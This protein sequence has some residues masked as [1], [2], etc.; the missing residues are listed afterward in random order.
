MGQVD[1]YPKRALRALFQDWSKR[2]RRALSLAAAF[3][4]GLSAALTVLIVVMPGSPGPVGWYVL[5]ASHTA[6]IASLIFGVN[7]MF[8]AHDPR[9]ISQVRGALGEDNTRCELA[10]AKRKGVIWGWVDSVPYQ[11]GDIDHVV[12]TRRGGVVA[13]DSKW[14]SSLSPAHTHELS[15]AANRAALLTA[16]LARTVLSPDRGEHRSRAKAVRVSPVIALWGA[17]RDEL[18][19][20]GVDG[21]PIVTGRGVV[22]WL[23][24]LSGDDVDEDA[25]RELIRLIEQHAVGVRGRGSRPSG[26]SAT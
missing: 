24:K 16:A 20:G 1:S 14:R 18:P 26:A 22:P 5:G 17:A 6:L 8:L 25:A 15:L 13:I 9:A 21:V 10:R 4:I 7:H 19:A 11:G 23:R 12:V 2:N 3:I